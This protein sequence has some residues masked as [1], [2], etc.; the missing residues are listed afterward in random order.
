MHLQQGN[1]KKGEVSDFGFLQE[2]LPFQRFSVGLHEFI[3]EGPAN[4][5]SSYSFIACIL[6]SLQCNHKT[7][8][9]VSTQQQVF[10]QALPWYG[11]HPENILFIRVVKPKDLLWVIDEVLK[12]SAVAAL[13]CQVDHLGFSNSRRFQLAMEKSG[14]IS[15]FLRPS[16]CELSTAC[17]ARWQISPLNSFK[18]NDLPGVGHPHWQVHLLKTKNGRTGY[19]KLR[20][21][22]GKFISTELMHAVESFYDWKKTG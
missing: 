1:L 13:V 20:W 2:I 3:C 21:V 10:P 14:V 6:S 15:F 7:T 18:S 22:N 19:W 9:W 11:L 17:A 12:C 8:V 4:T 5:A 16:T